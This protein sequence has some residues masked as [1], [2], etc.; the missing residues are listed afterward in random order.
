[1]PPDKIRE[2]NPS[3]GPRSRPKVQNRSN[4]YDGSE[5]RLPK[6]TLTIT[7]DP[8]EVQVEDTI[9]SEGARYILSRPSE[10]RED[11][12]DGVDPREYQNDPE[13]EPKSCKPHRPVGFPPLDEL[14]RWFP[15]DIKAIYQVD[16]H[17]GAL[18]FKV[19][20]LY[21]LR[22]HGLPESGTQCHHQISGCS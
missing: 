10:H 21:C 6:S 4:P 9:V 14:P 12:V 19:C 7:T 2:P 11:A 15:E 8:N 3:Q 20:S 16:R 22:F 5:L 13:Y 18:S 1:M 17:G